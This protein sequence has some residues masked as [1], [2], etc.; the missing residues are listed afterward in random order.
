M[1]K[2]LLTL[3]FLMFLVP[4]AYADRNVSTTTGYNASTLVKRGDWQIYR[5]TYTVSSNSGQF[6]IYDAV[7]DTGANADIK[8]EGSE[9]TALNGKFMDFTNKPLKGSTGLYLYIVNCNVIV[10]YE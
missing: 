5:I 10:E 3:L 6:V 4:F 1:K 7:T 2:F 8:T 9:A